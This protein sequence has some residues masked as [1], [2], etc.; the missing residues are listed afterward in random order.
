MVSVILPC[1][2]VEK[3][4]GDAIECILDQSYDDWEMVVVNDGSTDS[5]LDIAKDY[6]FDDE[7]IKIISKPNGGVA[8]ARVEGLRNAAGDYIVFLDPDDKCSRHYLTHL[9]FLIE[10]YIR[11]KGK[12]NEEL[13]AMDDEEELADVIDT[14]VD[15]ASCAMIMY[16]DDGELNA[17]IDEWNRKY[18]DR[19]GGEIMD[20]SGEEAAEM[21]M[22]QQGINT[23]LCGKIFK[24]RL[25]DKISFNE[26]EVYEDLNVMY[27][28]MLES[29]R[30]AISTAPLY[31]YFVA[32]EGSITNTFNIKRLG[33][34][35]VTRRMQEYIEANYPRLRKGVI[36]RRMSA[37][38]NMLG[39]LLLY[40]DTIN[41]TTKDD[42]SKRAEQEY[43][44]EKIK[45]CR[46][47]I[48]ANRG[49]NIFNS[50]LRKKSRAGVFLSYLPRCLFEKF[51][52]NRYK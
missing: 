1:Y 37:N 31:Y 26:G 12:T 29:R 38:F 46:D 42:E 52:K 44:N 2:N 25:F 30:V 36:E 7:R 19:V 49:V 41:Y 20:V 34:L 27:R 28:L 48:K 14:E 15:M 43:I 6:A 45:E 18:P 3:Y 40:R 50:A 23:S 39:L 17:R 21:G 16:S 33:V 11:Y 10:D 5:T 35:D 32:R 9:M 51:L 24:R 13:D 8:S 4:I 47:Y 22:Y